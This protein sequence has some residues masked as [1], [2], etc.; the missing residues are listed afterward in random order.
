MRDKTN[1]DF[2]IARRRRAYPRLWLHPGYDPLETMTTLTAAPPPA[3]ATQD[4]LT[5]QSLQMKALLAIVF[6]FPVVLSALVLPS[7][8]PT[9]ASTSISASPTVSPRSRR[10]RCR[11]GWRARWR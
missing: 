11:P 10:R 4:V 8:A 3:T 5:L 1:P 9:C 7:P 6:L 2:A